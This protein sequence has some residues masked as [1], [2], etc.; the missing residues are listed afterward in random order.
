MSDTILIEYRG[1]KPKPLVREYTFSVRESAMEPQECTLTIAN[2]AFDSHRARYQDAPDICS[3]KLRRELAANA[4]H[5]PKTHYRITDAELDDYRI[6][7][8]PKP[9]R[10]L[11][12]PRA[13][14]DL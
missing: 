6:A 7:H 9:A 8:G 10:N 1:F 5:L 11:Y 14:R 12:T 13:S 4:N 2:E 3:L